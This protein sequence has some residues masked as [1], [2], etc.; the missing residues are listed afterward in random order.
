MSTI[1]KSCPACPFWAGD[2]FS[3][4]STEFKHG[5]FLPLKALEPGMGQVTY[6]IALLGE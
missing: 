1:P 3:L 5:G 4:A 2:G 6:E